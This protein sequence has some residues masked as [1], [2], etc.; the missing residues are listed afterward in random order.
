MIIFGLNLTFFKLSSIFEKAGAVL[1][2]GLCQKL[3]HHQEI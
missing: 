2:I 3:K 1:K